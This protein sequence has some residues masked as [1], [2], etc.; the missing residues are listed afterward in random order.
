MTWNP[1]AAPMMSNC[2]RLAPTTLREARARSGSSGVRAVAWRTANPASRATA[3]TPAHQSACEA[4]AKTPDMIPE[5]ASSAP[6]TSAPARRPRPRSAGSTRHAASQATR[7]TGRF[8]KKIQCQFA[9][10][11][12][13]PPMMSPADAPA[14]PVKANAPIALVCSPGA[15]NSRTIM[16]SVTADTSAAPVPWANRA[17]ISIAGPAARPQTS[18]ARTN[19]AI[20]ARNIRLRPSRSPRRPL[21]RSNPPKAMR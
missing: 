20:P 7:P 2:A 4:I 9:Y 8:T 1:I 14:A 5:V 16:P 10:C 11:T 18:E 17:A 19:T 15:G 13:R 6:G 12:S 3:T 21:S